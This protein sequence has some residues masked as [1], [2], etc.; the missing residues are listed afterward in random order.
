MF[1]RFGCSVALR[2]PGHIT[3]IPP[4]W[5]DAALE[6]EF[7]ESIS[8][9]ASSQKGFEIALQN[10]SFFKPKV[11]FVDV[12][13]NDSLQQLHENL[14]CYLT[15]KNHFHIKKE[16]RRFHPHITIATRDLPKK[17]F[18]KARE[19][20]REK[21]YHA[22]WQADSISILRHDQKKWDVISTSLFQSFNFNHDHQ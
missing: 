17:D 15:A 5:M 8:N 12:V 3:L 14:S 20:F 10:F 4:F 16:E 19:I 13:K 7:Q 1:D 22:C 6:A 2:S 18:Y 9:F 11:I 21:K